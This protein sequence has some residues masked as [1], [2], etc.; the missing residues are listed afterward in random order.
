MKVSASCRRSRRVFPVQDGHAVS[1][2]SHG[3]LAYL[4]R[5]LSC[6]ISEVHLLSMPAADSMCPP[7]FSYEK[8]LSPSV[9]ALGGNRVRLGHEA[10]AL[11]MELVAF[12]TQ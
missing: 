2:R 9:G 7:P 3:L 6:V 10:E 1:Q 4:V 8:A 12:K 11:L 5:A